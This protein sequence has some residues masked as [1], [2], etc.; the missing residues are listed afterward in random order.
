MY[1]AV[2]ERPLHLFLQLRESECDAHRLGSL[3]DSYVG[4]MMDVGVVLVLEVME[5]WRVVPMWMAHALPGRRM[6][7]CR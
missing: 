7:V 5:R 4:E 2:G 1:Q 6:D 3:L